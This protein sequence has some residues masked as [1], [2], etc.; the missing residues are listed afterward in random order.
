MTPLEPPTTS[1]LMRRLDRLDSDLAARLERME[2]VFVRREVFDAAVTTLHDQIE[3]L[4]LTIHEQSINRRT[5]AVSVFIGSLAY[6]FL[7]VFVAANTAARIG[8][9][10]P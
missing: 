7:F 2:S 10:M 6:L 5:F 3:E 8:G 4:D 1:E 9:L